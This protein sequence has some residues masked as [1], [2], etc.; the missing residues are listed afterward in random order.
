M[1]S[2]YDAYFFTINMSLLV[3]ETV[4]ESTTYDAL[5]NAIE[6][7]VKTHTLIE[8]KKVASEIQVVST[9]TTT[10]TDTK[11]NVTTEK[12]TLTTNNSEKNNEKKKKQMK[13]TA[14]I[15]NNDAPVITIRM[16]K[17][18]EAELKIICEESRE[19]FIP[20]GLFLKL[21]PALDYLVEEAC[22]T[23]LYPSGLKTFKETRTRTMCGME[24]V[25]I[26]LEAITAN[27][28]DSRIIDQ[29]RI[30]LCVKLCKHYLTNL[31]FPIFTNL[32]DIKKKAWQTTVFKWT[33]EI[34]IGIS[35]MFAYLKRLV[36]KIPVTDS[37]L[38]QLTSLSMDILTL[39]GDKL[40]KVK[41]QVKNL[42]LDS[43]SLMQQIFFSHMQHRNAIFED[44][45]G[46]LHK[47]PG[48]HSGNS[49][50]SRRNLRLYSLIGLPIRLASPGIDIEKKRNS[51]RN[52]YSNEHIM[53]VSALILQLV[54]ASYI[55][56][57][58]LIDY[59]TEMN[60][61]TQRLGQNLINVRKRN[62]C[63]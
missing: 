55:K 16:L 12:E 37:L 32:S 42:Q 2:N 29:D 22:K 1:Y 47:L 11:N 21:M 48:Y 31:I 57:T 34:H 51:K 24:A 30:E 39:D 63:K 40:S 53:M 17:K 62:R 61:L 28:I 15:D 46:I 20:D 5:T 50:G 26:I 13:K 9:S 18:V 25:I 60:D 56:P 4:V 19:R 59:G 58:F 54:H 27:D 7:V 33:Q 14:S 44:I 35:E 38:L 36:D 23:A 45:F 43:I 3:A 49:S 6:A 41:E 8:S 52:E 10:T